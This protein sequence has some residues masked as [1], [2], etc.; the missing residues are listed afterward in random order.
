MNI[1]TEKLNEVNFLITATIESSDLDS[2]ITRLAKEASTQMKVD[3]FR[4][5]KVPIAV[6]KKMHGEKLAQDAESDAV[7]NIL[8]NGTTEL[9]FNQSEIIGQ[10]TFKKFDKNDNGI[11]LEIEISTKPSFVL[12][13]YKDIAP[14][15]ERPEV[16]DSEFKERMDSIISD[17]APFEKISD[18]RAVIDGDMT[19]IDFEGSIDGVLFDGG[20]AKD[21]SL[22]IGSNQFIPGFEEQLIGMKMGE[23]KVITTPFPEDYQEKKLAGKNAD[24]KVVL[25]EIQEKGNA[26]LTDELAGK[27]LQGEENATVEMLNTKVKEQIAKEKLSKLYN[28]ELKPKL[29]ESLVKL[30][31]F[32]LP[33]NIVEQELD[34]KLNAKAGEMSKEELETYKNDSSKVATLRET[35]REEASESVK[36]TFI[37]DAVAKEEKIVVTDDEVSQTIYYEAMMNGQNPQETIEYYQKNNLIPAVRMGMIEDK[38]FSTLLELDK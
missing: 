21:F 18:D 10:P 19:K 4:K 17:S 20:A 11:E 1:T 34:A 23:E 9:G 3:G 7:Q 27:F 31:S 5:G 12:D 22:T 32:D 26:E 29:I 16:S 14:S 30:Y 38:L 36:A 13:G 28:D 25:N 2:K 37:V 8:K 24:F 15:Y 33:N 35:L 6:V